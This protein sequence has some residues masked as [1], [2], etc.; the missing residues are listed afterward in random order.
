MRLAVKRLF[1]HAGWRAGPVAALALALALTSAGPASAQPGRP[2][3][4]SLTGPR[5]QLASGSVSRNGTIRTPAASPIGRNGYSLGSPLG[6]GSVLN[7]RPQHSAS[8]RSI[9]LP[10]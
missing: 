8:R 5:G 9:I 7:V 3:M 1:H 6:R 10:G 2:L 4:P